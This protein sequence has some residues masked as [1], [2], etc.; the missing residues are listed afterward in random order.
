MAEARGFTATLV[1]QTQRAISCLLFRDGNSLRALI[2]TS[3]SEVKI[4]SSKVF[5][6]IDIF[7]SACCLAVAETDRFVNL[8]GSRVIPLFTY[9]KKTDQ[10]EPLSVKLP[11][12]LSK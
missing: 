6:A 7:V 2:T 10:V 1:I 4:V 3:L 9:G 8:A 5:G 12:R 11:K